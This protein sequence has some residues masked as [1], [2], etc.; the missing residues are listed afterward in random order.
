MINYQL[1]ADSMHY[2]AAHGYQAIDAPWLISKASIDITR[3]EG[4]RYFETFAGNL[5]ASGEQSFLHIRDSLKPGRYQC[6]T[7]CFRDEKVLDDLHRLYF[8]KVELIEVRP[9]NPQDA[10]KLMISEAVGF[11]SQYADGEVVETDQGL[12]IFINGVE[13]GSYGIRK[14]EDFLWVYGTGIAEP[15]FSQALKFPRSVMA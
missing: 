13:V 14:H 4:T 5:V 1:I 2:Y 7:P 6:A 15:R 10:L 3:P 9:P 12:D 11:F 8:F